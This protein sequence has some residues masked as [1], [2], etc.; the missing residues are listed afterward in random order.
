MVRQL[1]RVLGFVMIAN[2]AFDF[3]FPEL[4]KEF[5]T[6]GPGRKWAF[7]NRRF[8]ETIAHLSAPSRRYLAIWEGIIGA[9]LVILTTGKQQISEMPAEVLPERPRRV[10]IP[11]HYVGR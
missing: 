9:L 2:A 3:T 1:V 5:L 7:P 8:V 6:R 4:G 11:I 10:R